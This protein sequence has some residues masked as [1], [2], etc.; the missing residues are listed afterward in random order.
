[1]NLSARLDAFRHPSTQKK[2]AG[3]CRGIEREALRITPA[4]QLA[5]TSHPES[6]GST[7]T[8]PLITTDYAESLMEFITPV[9]R[10]VRDTL[11]QLRD[12]HRYTY[13]HI[14]DEL[15]WPLS[16]PC[17]V[18]EP[19]DIHIADFGSSH[20]GTMKS[21]YRRGLTHRYGAVMQT[22]AGVHYNFS[23]PEEAWA[24]LAEKEGMRDC[25]EYRSQRY[26]DLIRNFKKIAWV[27][28][29]FFGA[30]PVVCSSFVRHSPG[31]LDLQEFGGGMLFK[32]FATAL[33]MSDLGYT[34]K[35]QAELGITYNSL[36]GYIDGLRRAVSTPSE[37]FAKIG[38]RDG[39]EFRQL[40]SNILQI[41]NEF[42][43]P[44]RPKRTAE[45]GETPTQAL[46]RGGVEYIEVRALDVNP[47]TPVGITAEQMYFLDLLLLHCLFSDSPTLD[48]EQQQEA[49]KNLNLVVLRGREPRLRLH[50]GER[51]VTLKEKLKD[52]FKEL[53]Q[54][55]EVL[56]NAYHADAYS[57]VLDSLRGIIENPEKSISGQLIRAMREAQQH[58][59]GFAMRLASSYR[60]QLISEDLDFY[61]EQELDEVAS[62]SLVEQRDIENQQQG[63]FADYL[64]AYFVAA[65]EKKKR[66]C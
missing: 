35:E 40:N 28:P 63:S 8:H 16:M 61:T 44:I 23:V 22:I 14:G 55:A 27:I 52:L 13:R 2:L 39:D 62:R 24:V 10:S 33:R 29:Y 59:R 57:C 48:W 37:R 34:N 12:L 46:E 53:D 5:L 19:E 26:F 3:I 60:E 17:Y 20:V 38:V 21:V 25:V 41:E 54:V 47:F 51:E 65:E 66:A 11:N 42:Y 1:M 58:G 15:L 4:G 9:A 43:S 31:D 36:Q 45:S 6:L 30:S 64:A 32:P 18:N 50:Q 7:L 49:E 56:D